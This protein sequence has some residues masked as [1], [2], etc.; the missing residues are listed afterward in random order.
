MSKELKLLQWLKGKQKSLTIEW[1][2]EVSIINCGLSYTNPVKPQC[3][4]SKPESTVWLCD[5]NRR[6]FQ[7]ES[8]QR[9]PRK[10]S[11]TTIYRAHGNAHVYKQCLKPP[12]PS[13][14]PKHG[15]GTLFPSCSPSK[16]YGS[17]PLA[18]SW[19]EAVSVGSLQVQPGLGWLWCVVNTQS[20]YNCLCC[21]PLSHVLCA[22]HRIAE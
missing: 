3:V 9:H 7:P 5:T 22:D 18:H 20:L 13:Q 8:P 4:C 11:H 12:Q 17:Q 21:F 19:L 15:H 2:A 1:P 6:T 16:W 10:T 14:A